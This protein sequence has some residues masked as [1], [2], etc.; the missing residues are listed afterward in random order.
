MTTASY[1][2]GAPDGARIVATHRRTISR[3]LRAHRLMLTVTAVCATVV[4]AATAQQVAAHGWRAFVFRAAGV[5][6][7][8]AHED[9]PH[10]ATRPAATPSPA[11]PSATSAAPAAAAPKATPASTPTA[12][13]AAAP[14]AAP[15]SP[16]ASAPANANR[17][18]PNHSVKPH[19]SVA[20]HAV[21]QQPLPPPRRRPRPPGW[22]PPPRRLPPP[23]PPF[24]R[25]P[26][27]P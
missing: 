18:A 3:Q 5:G 1:A 11:T 10:S 19:R 12:A 26:R 13:P 20:T 6:G 7:S 8:P 16:P 24:G 25:P 21:H 15:A 2:L 14:R 9:T 22:M 17:V 27:E 23:P 4:V